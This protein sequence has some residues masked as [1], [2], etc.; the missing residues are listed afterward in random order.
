[1]SNRLV[2]SMCFQILLSIAV[3]VAVPALTI[4]LLYFWTDFYVVIL[5]I[6]AAAIVSLF[7]RR[8][9]FPAVVGLAAWVVTVVIVLEQFSKTFGD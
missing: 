9:R 1:M 4:L 2:R 6:P 7:F 5:I 8:T 3:A